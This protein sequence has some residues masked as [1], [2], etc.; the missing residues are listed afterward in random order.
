MKALKWGA[1]T[2]GLLVIVYLVAS[3]VYGLAASAQEL[4]PIEDEHCEG[5]AV[6]YYVKDGERTAPRR[7][8]R[9]RGRTRPRC[10]RTRWQSLGKSHA[11]TNLRRPGWA[12]Q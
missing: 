2:L 3:V 6:G 9:S 11:G 10:L 4:P 7:S 12:P 1:I 8:W 5:G